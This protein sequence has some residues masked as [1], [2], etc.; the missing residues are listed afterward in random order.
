MMTFEMISFEMTVAPFCDDLGQLDRTSIYKRYLPD[1]E[2]WSRAVAP[3]TSRGG[4]VQA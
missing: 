1:L 2:Q 4:L 3:T